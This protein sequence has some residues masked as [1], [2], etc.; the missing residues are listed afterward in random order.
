MLR[1]HNGA[2]LSM[3]NTGFLTKKGLRGLVLRN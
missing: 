3:P 2:Q 1:Y